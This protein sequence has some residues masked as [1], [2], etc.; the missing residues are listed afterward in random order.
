MA[1]AFC[2]ACDC[3]VYVVRRDEPL[4]PRCSSSLLETRETISKRV[5]L[6]VREKL[7][8]RLPKSRREPREA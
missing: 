2:G 7:E 8:P 1:I 5:G 4:C 3:Q 6:T